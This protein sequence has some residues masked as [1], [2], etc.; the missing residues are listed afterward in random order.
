MP[1]LP[2][3]AYGDAFASQA[4]PH[5]MV[6]DKSGDTRP[7]E[8]KSKGEKTRGLLIPLPNDKTIMMKNTRLP[9]GHFVRIATKFH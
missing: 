1:L 3:P 8:P 2:S 9:D 5:G 7:M 4:R 6:R